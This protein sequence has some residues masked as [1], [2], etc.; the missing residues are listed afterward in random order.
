MIALKKPKSYKIRKRKA[1]S[2]GHI[3]LKNCFL[4]HMIEGRIEGRIEAT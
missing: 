1:N 2:I 4:K 3:L